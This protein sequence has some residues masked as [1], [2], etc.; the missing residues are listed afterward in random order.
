MGKFKFKRED[1][2]YIYTEDEDGR[3]TGHAKAG[4]GSSFADSLRNGEVSYVSAKDPGVAKKLNVVHEQEHPSGLGKNYYLSDNTKTDDP[5]IALAVKNGEVGVARM[6]QKPSTLSR[7]KDFVEQAVVP[8]ARD[9]MRSTV[10][11]PVGAV[12]ELASSQGRRALKAVGDAVEPLAEGLGVGIR[13]SLREMG[14]AIAPNLVERD[15]GMQKL[16]QSQAALDA[17]NLTPQAQAEMRAMDPNWKPGMTPSDMPVQSDGVGGPSSGPFGAPYYLMSAANPGG[18]ARTE[19][20]V[21]TGGAPRVGVNMSELDKARKAEAD[22]IDRQYAAGAQRAAEEA[23]YREQALREAEAQEQKRQAFEQRAVQ[24]RDAHLKKFEDA[25]RELAAISTKVDPGR[26]WASKDTP[27]KLAAVVGIF[28]GG[29][30]NGPNQALGIVQQAVDADIDAQKASIQNAMEQ[31]R[32]KVTS[33]QT[34][35]G[36]ALDKLGDDRAAMALSSATA[37][38]MLAQRIDALTAK[39]ASPE[40]TA[41]ADQ[42]RAQLAQS[43]AKDRIQ[44]QQWAQEMGLKRAQLELSAYELQQKA[45]AKAA[46][47]ELPAG[48]ASA[49]GQLQSAQK[50]IGDIDSAWAKKTGLMSWM[51]KHIPGFDA[52]RYANDKLAFAQGFGTILEEGKLT[53]ADLNDKYLPLAPDASDSEETKNQKLQS[54]R[55]ILQRKYEGKLEGF[56]KSGYDV[57]GFGPTMSQM[58]TALGITPR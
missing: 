27:N 44:A 10:L 55:L 1:D 18:G 22:A 4:M 38:E 28:L 32:N 8:T 25:Q 35:Y 42:A 23:G 37:K 58:N 33:A 39:Y 53:D 51:T 57:T 17:P 13:G 30:G 7:A 16:V 29:L 6:P 36:M 56:Q 20:S 52:S 41:K 46:G 31:G 19:T 9:V 14:H 45:M 15:P 21:R 26:L 2:Q 40:M 50:M 34:L 12:N 3:V 24:I 43:A 11:G 54:L 48:E 47:K 49:L 5:E